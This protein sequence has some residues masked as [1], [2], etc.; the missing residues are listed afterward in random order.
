M[1][2]II[3]PQFTEPIMRAIADEFAAKFPGRFELVWGGGVTLPIGPAIA[4]L[5]RVEDTALGVRVLLVPVCNGA[6]GYL[7]VEVW[8]G[9]AQRDQLDRWV[10]SLRPMAAAPP[11][12][13]HEL[14]PQ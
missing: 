7:F 10:M 3:Q 5:Y 8:D 11:L 13:C 9:D 4:R 14:D 12:I 6:G 2:Q 1:P